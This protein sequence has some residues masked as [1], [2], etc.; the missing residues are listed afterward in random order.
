MRRTPARRWGF[1]GRGI[2]TTA[3]SWAWARGRAGDTGTA[4]ASTASTVRA[5]GATTAAAAMQPAADIMAAE[6]F[7]AAAIAVGEQS[8]RARR[9]PVAAG[10][11]PAHR[12]WLRLAAVA[13][14]HHTATAVEHRM[15]AVVEDMP[16]PVAKLMAAADI[17]KRSRRIRRRGE[18]DAAGPSGTAAFVCAGGGEAGGACGKA[19]Q[20]L[21][22]GRNSRVCCAR[23]EIRCYRGSIDWD[24]LVIA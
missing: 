19:R 1:T 20:L 23:R 11:V 2:S 7:A 10:R 22:Q 15:A 17:D 4:G 6:K 16:E 18:D 14:K 5:A 8:I 9:S 21:L 13:L 24:D 3:S 12:T